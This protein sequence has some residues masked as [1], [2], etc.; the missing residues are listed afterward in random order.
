MVHHNL[1]KWLLLHRKISALIVVLLLVSIAIPINFVKK[2]LFPPQ[3]DREIRLRYNIDGKYRLAKIVE[4][5]DRVE[6]YLF[7]YQD[8]FEIESVYSY[9][10]TDYAAS[11]IIL[12]EKEDA[13]KSLEQI[14]E[15]IRADLPKLAIAEPSFERNRTSGS[16]EGVSKAVNQKVHGA[17]GTME[18]I[19]AAVGVDIQKVLQGAA[20]KVG[21]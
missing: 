20:K 11:T 1:L 17:L 7:E 16:G 12:K 6:E 8:K 2:D 3:E 21:S 19:S 9:Y 14:K 13:T 15:E 4:A 5:V 18:A 10:Q